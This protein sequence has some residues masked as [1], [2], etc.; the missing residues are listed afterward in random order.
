MAESGSKETT[1]GTRSG[2]EE[3]PSGAQKHISRRTSVDTV[4][5]R[6]S[7]TNRIVDSDSDR[8][9]IAK[10]PLFIHGALRVR[11]PAPTAIVAVV[12]FGLVAACGVGA[13]E[14]TNSSSEGSR[15]V[16]TTP[17]TSAAGLDGSWDL[18]SVEVNGQPADPGQAHLTIEGEEFGGEGACAG[19]G[20][21][22]RLGP[23][24]TIS[25]Y[26][27]NED[28]FGCDEAKSAAQG[29][30]LRHLDEVRRYERDDDL[31]CFIGE[32]V[33]LCFEAFT[34]PSD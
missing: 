8:T 20:G 6:T 19:I 23:N 4:V 15:S 13:R 25:F 29:V 18:V 34:T 3:T 12:L 1:S 26:D 32:E 22:I 31:L 17:N 33:R 30:F 24:G 10:P 7:A 11:R 9:H 28:L 14:G 5:V 16:T 27:V 2:T 21:Q